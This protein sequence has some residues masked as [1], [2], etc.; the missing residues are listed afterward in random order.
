MTH[1]DAYALVERFRNGLR[2]AGECR[3][4]HALTIVLKSQRRMAQLSSIF[5]KAQDR[6][7]A[8]QAEIVADETQGKLDV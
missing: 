2:E 5:A 1:D 6:L 8:I 7:Q 3:L 4:E